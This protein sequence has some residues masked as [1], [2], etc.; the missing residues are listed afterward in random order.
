[1]TQTDG[2][3]RVLGVPHLQASVANSEDGQPVLVPK[4]RQRF[5]FD[6]E[7]LEVDV[8]QLVA[9]NGDLALLIQV[10]NPSLEMFSAIVL[11]DFLV[12]LIC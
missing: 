2:V 9:L 6:E 7:S 12:E 1:M 10:G 5:R 3:G 4:P 11:Q 8:G